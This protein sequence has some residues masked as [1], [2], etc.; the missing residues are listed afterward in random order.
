MIHWP[1]KCLLYYIKTCITTKLT[2][3]LQFSFS[4][5]ANFPLACHRNIIKQIKQIYITT[6]LSWITIQYM[7]QFS[8][9]CKLISTSS[10]SPGCVW[11]QRQELW[12]LVWWRSQTLPFLAIIW[13]LLEVC[14]Q[15]SSVSLV[16]HMNLW[17][18]I[19]LNPTPTT[20]KEQQ[21]FI[22]T[23]AAVAIH[24]QLFK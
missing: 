2:Y 8:L 12:I 21:K 19:C 13:T 3:E 24:I 17:S 22:E 5:N 10:S 9:L 18:N 11:I 15:S 23:D 16:S 4:H 14:S 6:I 1:Y 20:L 7:P